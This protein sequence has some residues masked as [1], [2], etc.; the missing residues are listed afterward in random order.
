[1]CRIVKAFDSIVDALIQQ[2][3]F[4][5][6]SVVQSDLALKG[7]RVSI[8]KTDLMMPLVIL[9]LEKAMFNGRTLNAGVTGTNMCKVTKLFTTVYYNCL[10]LL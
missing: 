3:N 2:E 1:M 7:E 5:N 10:F 6:I 8:L 9:Q 4:S